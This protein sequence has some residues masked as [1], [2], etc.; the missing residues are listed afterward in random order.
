MN[1]S[2]QLKKKEMNK[3]KGNKEGRKEELRPFI[4]KQKCYT[5]LQL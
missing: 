3:I 2:E 4:M 1:E 5:V